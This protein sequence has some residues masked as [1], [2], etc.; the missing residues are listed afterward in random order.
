MLS[1][2]RLFIIDVLMDD[3]EDIDQI[4]SLLH[5]PEIGWVEENEGNP[6]CQDEVLENLAY[7]VENCYIE[8]WLLDKDGADLEL[9][10][11]PSLDK[12][13]LKECWFKPTEKGRRE[14]EKALSSLSTNN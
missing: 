2:N 6:F 11:T 4:M 1:K 5:D 12:K 10:P 7:L 14:G 8:C 13:Q 9:D 3:I